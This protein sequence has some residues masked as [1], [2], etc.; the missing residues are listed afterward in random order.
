MR[1]RLFETPTGL[2]ALILHDDE[3]LSTTW[4][5]SKSDPRIAKS[6]LDRRLLPELADR[7]KRYFDGQH[8][9][10]ADVSTPAGAEFQVKCW[11]ACR[12]IPRGQTRSYAHLAILAGSNAAGARAAGQA[13][14]NNPLPIIIPCHR[15]LASDGK[16]HGF[17]GSSDV[18]GRELGVKRF[19]L[20]L[21]GAN[22]PAQ[23]LQDDSLAV[24]AGA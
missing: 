2:F 23:L 11:N 24:G 17:G 9:G 5:Q 20:E 6:R 14:R 8:V 7:I 13:M 16:L 19:L 12:K 1:H 18:N 4:V 3:S 22:V 10:F 15:V 21:E